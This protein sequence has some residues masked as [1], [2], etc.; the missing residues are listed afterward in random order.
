MKNALI[1][2]VTAAV[3]LSSG[4]A[5]AGSAGHNQFEISGFNTNVNT[6]DTNRAVGSKGHHQF[7][8][9]GFASN[10]NVNFNGANRTR[11][12]AAKEFAPWVATN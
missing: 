1:A 8:N 2:T 3:V 11:N 6:G 4:A 7:N 12:T 9:Q 10:G 5:I